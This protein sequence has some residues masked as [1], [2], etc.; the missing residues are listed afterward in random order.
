MDGKLIVFDDLVRC[1]IDGDATAEEFQDLVAM[2]RD[3]PGLQKR[4]CRQM[5]IHA[6]L[7]CHKGQE[8]PDENDVRQSEA[9]RSFARR[10]GPDAGQTPDAGGKETR[11]VAWRWAAAAAILL[12]GVAAWCC[13][14]GASLRA[15]IEAKRLGTSG[16]AV[17]VARLMW[18]K[19]VK[20][21]DLPGTL[22]GTLRLESGVVGV[23]LQTGVELSVIGPAEVE[24]QSGMRIHLER[25]RL[26]ADVPHWATG[27][28]VRTKQFEVYD[29]GTV[30][31]VSV[32]STVSD[33]FVFK[34]SVQVN[35]RKCEWGKESFEEGV[36]L[37]EAG[38]G[39]R[40]LTGESPVKFAADWPAAK[41]L[42]STVSGPSAA[43]NPAFAMK[44]ATQIET[45]WSDRNMPQ[46]NCVAGEPRSASAVPSRKAA[47]VRSAKAVS[48]RKRRGC[49][50]MDVL[51]GA[52]PGTSS[53]PVQVDS[54]PCGDNR[55]WSTVFTNEV[56]LRW[57]WP[58]SATTA[59]LEIVGMN[60]VLVTNFTP[61]TSFYLW[62]PFAGRVPSEEDIYTLCL[63][64]Y[65]GEMAVAGELTSRL[66]VL[67]GAF[68][69]T[70]VDLR[71]TGQPAVFTKRSMVIP[72]DACWDASTANASGCMLAVTTSRKSTQVNRF[73][74]TSGYYGY[75][76]NDF[77]CGTFEW[78]LTFP[79]TEGKW[80]AKMSW[81]L[82]GMIMSVR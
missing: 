35:E 47:W 12:G 52:A 3:A 7:T 11:G 13:G 61:G 20:G 16:P 40:A 36:G 46:R 17:P 33:V 19:N 49:S 75:R 37:C 4:Y 71:P 60:S 23:R 30:F 58:L 41:E 78:G 80:D 57:D 14:G 65:K 10:T 81:S 5:Q 1:V 22:P 70:V 38:E 76:L 31:G 15:A 74:E 69:K 82:G 28:T 50:L 48:P 8:W 68:G 42:F 53:G 77:G 25:G 45:L 29:L 54:S 64:F 39:V 32:E 24:V 43:R 67:T 51:S 2:M 44:I 56:P 18:Q 34:G 72:Y 73:A 66:A 6:L 21:L 79:G 59:E 55:R 62:R 26:L 63:T 9:F 27:F